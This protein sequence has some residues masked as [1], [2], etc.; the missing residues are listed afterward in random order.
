M[1]DLKVKIGNTI[2]DSTQTPIMIIF[3]KE[4]IQHMQNIPENNHKYCSFP[5][6]S[7]DEDIDEFMRVDEEIVGFLQY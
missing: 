6:D 3:D 1:F 4:E 2:Y 7:K 5:D